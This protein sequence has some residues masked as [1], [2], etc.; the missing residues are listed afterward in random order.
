[1][2]VDKYHH[3]LVTRVASTLRARKA[4]KEWVAL[5]ISPSATFAY[6]WFIHAR[7]RLIDTS[8]ELRDLHPA[9]TLAV[10]DVSGGVE[11]FNVLLFYVLFDLLA[12]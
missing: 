5:I 4:R 11:R 1:M 7:A 6:R 3:T 2:R 8:L 10:A 12:D 9:D